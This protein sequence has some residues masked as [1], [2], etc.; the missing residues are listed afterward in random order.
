MPGD[1]LN[2][3]NRL[4]ELGWLGGETCP[5]R[6]G[7]YQRQRLVTN[8]SVVDSGIR[9]RV[10]EGANRDSRIVFVGYPRRSRRHKRF[11]KEQPPVSRRGKQASPCRGGSLG[12][13]RSLGG[14]SMPS[15]RDR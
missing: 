5:Q 8:D 6:R 7:A 11:P 13:V 12:N 1:G 9:E 3:Q 10:Y 15:R 2:R 4:G 14:E